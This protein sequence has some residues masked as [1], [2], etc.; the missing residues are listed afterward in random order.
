[1]A[2]EQDKK[3]LGQINDP[4]PVIYSIGKHEDIF[5]S[6][7]NVAWCFM[8]A[9]MSQGINSTHLL[10]KSNRSGNL[11]HL[12]NSATEEQSTRYSPDQ[13]YMM[14]PMAEE[15]PSQMQ[16]G[17]MTATPLGKDPACL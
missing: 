5:A 14:K 15:L 10:Q 3:Y 7:A 12:L 13:S 6:C 9:I 2:K 1:M 16:P 4:V 17:S 11:S 8:Q